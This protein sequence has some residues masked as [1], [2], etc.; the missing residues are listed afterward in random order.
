MISCWLHLFTVLAGLRSCLIVNRVVELFVE[1]KVGVYAA[2]LFNG[3]SILYKHDVEEDVEQLRLK[4]W[5]SRKENKQRGRM[6]ALGH[7]QKRIEG[8][9]SGGRSPYGIHYIKK[10]KRFEIVSHGVE[11]LETIITKLRDGWNTSKILIFLTY[12]IA[13]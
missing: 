6:I 2:D 4:L 8:G 7:R 13:I 12:K 1:R 11:T 3:D 9:F 5:Q 10:E